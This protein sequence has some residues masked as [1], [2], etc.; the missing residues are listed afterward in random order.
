M[1]ADNCAMQLVRRPKQ[2]DVIVTDNLFG[3]LLSD[4]AAMLT[5]RLG[6]LPSA[7]LGAPDAGGRRKGLYEP[8][9]G[10]APDIAGQGLA[11][12]LACILSFAML[13]RYSFDLPDAADLVERAVSA[14]L[15]AGYRTPDIAQDG[16][17]RVGTAG[18]GD[19]VLKE[20]DRLAA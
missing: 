9:H 13:L 19:A 10:S 20:L 16:T 12:P 5:G 11:N 18:M 8:V 14:T 1:Y 15:D 2:F 7:S 4:C 3:D 6:M 17:T